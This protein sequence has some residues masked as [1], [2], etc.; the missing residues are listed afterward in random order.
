M[1]MGTPDMT[2][3]DMLVR[4]ARRYGE[5][6]AFVCGEARLTHASFLAKANRLASA[7]VR[8]GLRRQDRI[9]VL[10]MNSLEIAVTYG[11]CEAH[12]FV[13]AT[14]N[15]RLAAPE[16]RHIIQDSASSVLIFEAAY[17]EQIA[18]IR[19]DL[20]LVET[21]VVIGGAVE[22]AVGWDD[23]VERGDPE[24][25]VLA[26]PAADDLCYLIYTSGTTG[27]SKGCM[28]EH[29]AE[30]ATASIMAAAMQLSEHD[31]TLLMM[32]LF[33][34]G[35]K[36]VALAQQWVGGA[37][38][39]HRNF[40]PAAIL[41]DIEL[42]RITATHMAPT[43]IQGLLDSPDVGARD[44]SS[45]RT[46]L[47]SAAPMSPALLSRAL[48]VFGPIFQQMYGQTEGLGTLLP[49][50][51]HRLD[52]SEDVLR[53]LSS[54]GHPFIG[55]DVGI[56]DEDGRR[57]P[58]EAIGEICIRGPAMMRGYWN[59]SVAT[60]ETLQEGW[61]RTGDVGQADAAGYLYLVDRKKDVII[62]GGENIY[63][64][65][66][67]EA[68]LSHPDVAYAAV[69]GE[70]DEKWGEAVLA[71]VV[72]RPGVTGHADVLIDHCRSRIAGYKRPRRLVFLDM[73][74]ALPSGKID[75]P[76]LRR[77]LVTSVEA[78]S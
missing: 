23:F 44:L 58:P 77:Q 42:H 50:S 49:M 57:Q 56:F 65:E 72:M 28:L 66:V 68:L 25:P 11:A 9:A 16:M 69:I 75:K 8:S 48:A 30:T 54:I 1:I 22:W 29:R 40:D 43:L 74:P 13:A 52:G 55:C 37:V 34:I 61:L 78:R 5:R 2:L 35:A 51:A 24:G 4:N 12:G 6:D 53:R 21:Y 7:L 45:L 63:S 47:Y 36:A 18:S 70:P 3:R 41:A 17:I 76:A 19:P 20:P 38:Y 60:L 71:A 15:F 59:N 14:V 39:L 64:R 26:P 67:E 73:L 32:P 10:A 46:L 62:S 31:R 33:H 27:R